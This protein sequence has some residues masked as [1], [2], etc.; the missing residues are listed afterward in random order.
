MAPHLHVKLNFDVGS[1]LN[2]E[3]AFNAALPLG[4]NV[5]PIGPA[6]GPIGYAFDF[7]TERLR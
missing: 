4:F 3:L 1:D 6:K 2:V 7:E 5:E